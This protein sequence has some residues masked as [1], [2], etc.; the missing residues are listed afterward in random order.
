MNHIYLLKRLLPIV[1]I[2]IVTVI[3]FWPFFSKTLLPIPTDN[4]VGMFHP[5]DDFY[6]STFPRGVPFKNYLIS[7]PIKQQYPWRE[8]VISLEKKWQLPLWNPYSFAGTPLLGNVQSAPFYALNLLFF[9]FPFHIAWSIL[10]LLEPL[11]AG[12]FLYVYLRNLKLSKWVSVFGGISFAFSGFFTAWLEW[13]TVLHVGLWLPFI[14]LCID[15][16]YLN[17][18]TIVNSKFIWPI[19]FIFS[20]TSS[21]FAGHLQIFF[22]VFIVSIAYILFR[23]LEQ[24][25]N[26]KSILL[27]FIICLLFVFIIISI[28]LI[29]TLQFILLSARSID[30][31]NWRENPGWFVPWQHSIQF[32]VPDFFGNPATRNYTSIFNYGEL[33]GYIGIFP[34]LMAL[35]SL[36]FR[37]DRETVFFIFVLFTGIL[38]AFPTGVS[39]IPFMLQIPFVSTSQPTRLMFVIDFALTTLS[40]LG[41]DYY[42]TH[43]KKIHAPL[44][45]LFSA[46]C[47]LWLFV[48]FGRKFLPNPLVIQR[49]L[50][51]PSILFIGMSL[52]LFW[53]SSKKKIK[54]EF[55]FLGLLLLITTGDLLRFDSKYNVFQSQK[56]LFPQTKTISYLKQQKGLFRIMT[57]D[58]PVFPPN[59]SIIFRLQSLDGYDPLYLKRY[60]ELI[61]ALERKSPDISEPFGFNKIVSPHTIDSKLIDLLGAKY[62]LSRIDIQSPKL[63][64]VF[65][66]G[67]TRVYENPFAFSR[68]FFVT[69]T[70][71]FAKKQEI[72]KE[73]FSSDLH[74]IA[75]VESQEGCLGLDRNWIN[76]NA[77]VSYYSENKI[78]IHTQN[79]NEGF[80]VFVDS[81]YPTWHARIYDQNNKD[82]KDAKIYITDFNFRGVMVPKGNNTIEFYNS[83]L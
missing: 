70:K 28:Q 17:L 64:K 67:K 75:F 27:I 10:I 7:D 44:L 8:L 37:R 80:L 51:V 26:K 39:S 76:G 53:H 68:V 5:F 58:E 32:L 11:L 83:L 77:I 33:I 20:L 1:F 81:F 22:Y 6:R 23:L 82:S 60:A 56:F 72:I 54:H 66:E 41:I 13:G 31:A 48:L 38:F 45:L 18:N 30:Q 29:P 47:V 46:F 78:I 19:F 49:N 52:I 21:F 25:E 69:R 3:F 43:R 34:F 61:A 35:V 73:M 12:L 65:Q 16:I 55:I 40:A 62:I 2:F 36:F 42:L 9:M 79:E 57:T 24:N 71:C 50:Y 15:K 59:F 63:K 14:L 4:L 74:T